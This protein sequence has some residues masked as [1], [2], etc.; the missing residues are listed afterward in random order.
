MRAN[1]FSVQADTAIVFQKTFAWARSI[2][3]FC[4]PKDVLTICVGKRTDAR[5]GI[6]TSFE[7]EWERFV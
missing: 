1:F 3:Y 4:I 5:C 2:E 7:P 6:A